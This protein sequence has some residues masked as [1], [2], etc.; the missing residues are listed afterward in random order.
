MHT[1][2][3]TIE[4]KV[5]DEASVWLS[6]FT[7][8]GDEA[9]FARLLNLLAVDIADIYT[10]KLQ[11]T[12]NL[13]G[14]MQGGRVKLLKRDA[15]ETSFTDLLRLLGIVITHSRLAR[16]KAARLSNPAFFLRVGEDTIRPAMP[17]RHLAAVSGY[18]ERD[19]PLML[20]PMIHDGALRMVRDRHGND[21]VLVADDVADNDQVRR[22]L[23]F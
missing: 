7:T 8:G 20:A 13:C 16:A 6:A 11:H 12:V 23:K 15:P 17:L 10:S 9:E 3:D 22:L 14:A 1:G 19:L 5:S 18:A 4:R 21:A 2:T